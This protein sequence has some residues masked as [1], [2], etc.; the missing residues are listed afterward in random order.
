[1]VCVELS[2]APELYFTACVASAPHFA[3]DGSRDVTRGVDDESASLSLSLSLSLLLSLQKRDDRPSLGIVVD[4]V[5]NR[6]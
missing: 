4:N 3:S 6:R 1:M 5:A 2:A